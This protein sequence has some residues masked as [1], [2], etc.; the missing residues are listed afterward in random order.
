MDGAFLYWI[1]TAKDSTQIYQAKKSNGA[2]LSHVEALRSKHILVYSSVLQPFP[3]K[4][5]TFLINLFSQFRVRKISYYLLLQRCPSPILLCSQH[6]SR[7]SGFG[8]HCAC[9]C[10]G[11]HFISRCICGLGCGRPL[12]TWETLVLSFSFSVLLFFL[13]P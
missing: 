11:S 7:R 5:V 6:C 3:G 4:K 9:I 2:I 12:Q 10:P 1:S 8:A 13:I